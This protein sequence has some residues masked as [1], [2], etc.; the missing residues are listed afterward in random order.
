MPLIVQGFNEYGQI[1]LQPDE[2]QDLETISDPTL[3]LWPF[4]QTAVCLATTLF[5]KYDGTVHAVGRN[6]RGELGQGNT[7]DIPP[8]KRVPRPVQ[9]FGGEHIVHIS[10]G[11]AHCAA[12]SSAG[13]LFTWGQ[14]NYGQCG[15]VAPPPAVVTTATRCNT[16]ALAEA[17]VS[18]VACGDNHTVAVTRKGVAV[19]F[20]H[21]DCGQLGIG[22]AGQPFPPRYVNTPIAIRP[23]YSNH[24][25]ELAKTV[26]GEV[27]LDTFYKCACGKEG[28]PRV[29]STG[30]YPAIPG[31]Q[32]QAAALDFDEGCSNTFISGCSAGRKFTL[33]V[34][35][36]GTVFAMGTN[37][38][39]ELGIG[40]GQWEYT[41]RE[42]GA[43]LF[44]NEPVAAVS[45]GTK[46]SMAITRDT[47]KLFS[48]GRG[49]L[50]PH[51]F[52]HA[53]A[54]F[55]RISAGLRSFA[56]DDNGN[57]Y[58]VDGEDATW[59][60]ADNS[61]ER[62]CDKVSALSSGCTGR[63]FVW[64]TG[65]APVTPGFDTTNVHLVLAKAKYKAALVYYRQ[66]SSL[67]SQSLKESALTVVRDT[68]FIEVQRARD[69]VNELLVQH[70][71]PEQQVQP[72]QVESTG[73]G[74]ALAKKK[75]FIGNA[76]WDGSG[77]GAGESLSANFK[78]KF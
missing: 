43:E 58:E 78:F 13:H 39:D 4:E 7:N 51:L 1:L 54:R 69:R 42:L 5:L 27:I 11:S 19:S 59:E 68:A 37:A 15:I 74:G 52:N 12:V 45:C 55:V 49:N 10:A 73:G 38:D 70:G 44:N 21:N 65:I 28:G 23:F 64:I 16:S 56:L 30:I 71:F 36:I 53:L 9:G 63:H 62:V 67:N 35:N 22:F 17:L 34:T 46:H 40:I 3:D 77:G 50:Q 24:R 72:L 31:T 14:N 47:G 32:G 60:T 57:V 18:V 26:A 8:G 41:P 25:W 33:L 75:R 76:Q 20:G 66:L 29:G 48:W 6:Q 2:V 61:L